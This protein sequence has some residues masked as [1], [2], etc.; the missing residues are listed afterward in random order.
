[1]VV[2]GC[3]GDR[4]R[5]KRPL[6]G[7]EAASRADLLVVTSDNPRTEDPHAII[8]E[9]V[10]GVRAST[11]PEIPHREM[12]EAKSGFV[13]EADRRRAITLAIEAAR[14]GDTVL[15][16]GKGHEPYQIVGKTKF[17]FDDR[18]EVKRALE[19]DGRNS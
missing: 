16:A 2:F 1:M 5:E 11:L 4:D 3:G 17:A 14:P 10:P 13:I 7:K 15:I 12:A 18:V 9:I 6:M 8:D 19:R